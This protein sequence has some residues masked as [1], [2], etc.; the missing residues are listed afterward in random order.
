ML[1]KNPFIISPDTFAL[2]QQLQVLVELNEFY[3]VGVTSLALQMG[4]RNSIDIDLFTQKNFTGQSLAE[5]LEKYMTVRIDVAVNG[6]LLSHI[7]NI[8]VDFICQ[9]SLCKRTD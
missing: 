7:N 9:S 2:I 1:H 5:I 8:K 4:H 6:T 3:L